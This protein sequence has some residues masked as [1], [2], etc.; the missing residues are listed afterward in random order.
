MA[1]GANGGVRLRDN[2][3]GVQ[4]YISV[5]PNG[6]G[7]IANGNYVQYEFLFDQ[8]VTNVV[9]QVGGYNNGDYAQVNADLGGFDV[10]ID[11]SNLGNLIL[12]CFRFLGY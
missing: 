10:S 8:P 11:S 5:Q 12:P 9:I 2:L 7:V 1:N 4:D 3:V 6:T